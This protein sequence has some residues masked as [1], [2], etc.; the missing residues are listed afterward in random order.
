MLYVGHGRILVSWLYAFEIKTSP[1][2]VEE[3]RDKLSHRR[4]IRSPLVLVV[5]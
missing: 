5:P 3:A 4:I 1:R 2:D